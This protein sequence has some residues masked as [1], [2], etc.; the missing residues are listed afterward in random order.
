MIKKSQ[1]TLLK[2]KWNM[3]ALLIDINIIK[4]GIKCTRS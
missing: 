3:N 1:I 4:Y 2:D